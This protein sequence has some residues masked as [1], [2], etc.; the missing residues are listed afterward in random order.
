MSDIKL[1]SEVLEQ[2]E[3]IKAQLDSEGLKVSVEAKSAWLRWEPYLCL[4][5]G[6]VLGILADHFVARL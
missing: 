2:L 6:L 5:V 4:F 1:K 3:H